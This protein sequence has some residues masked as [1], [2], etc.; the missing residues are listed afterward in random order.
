MNGT[1]N[2]DIGLDLCVLYMQDINLRM[3]LIYLELLIGNTYA[4]LLL[5]Q[6]RGKIRM[7]AMYL[8][9]SIIDMKDQEVFDALASMRKSLQRYNERRELMTK[10]AAI[11]G[12]RIN[13][14]FSDTPLPEMNPFFKETLENL[15]NE[16]KRR[17]GVK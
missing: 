5:D 1:I 15:E 17:T 7:T 4:N 10:N 8:G 6:N 2:I 12:H 16:V 9:K 13:K 14:M 11:S 3:R